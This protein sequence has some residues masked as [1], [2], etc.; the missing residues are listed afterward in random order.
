[1][2]S[3]FEHRAT[4][5]VHLCLATFLASA[6][7]GPPQPYPFLFGGFFF[8]PVNI[9]LRSPRICNVS[10]HSA[11]SSTCFLSSGIQI[12][13]GSAG[14]EVASVLVRLPKLPIIREHL[15]FENGVSL[16]SCHLRAL[17]MPRRWPSP[18]L[19][20]FAPAILDCF[21]PFFNQEPISKLM[22]TSAS[23]AFKPRNIMQLLCSVIFL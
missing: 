2:R 7:T 11:I 1:M 5:R 13:S 8:Q 6:N 12:A 20:T 9:N 14:L 4:S 18:E 3:A 22:P 10:L 17:L 15:R 16:L 21:P 19:L 23:L